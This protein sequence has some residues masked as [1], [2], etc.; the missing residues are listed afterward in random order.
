MVNASAPTSPNPVKNVSDDYVRGATGLSLFALLN[1]RD[2]LHCGFHS[3][4]AERITEKSPIAPS[5]ISIQTKRK[6]PLELAI[7]LAMPTPFPFMWRMGTP[8]ERSEPRSI[9]T[10]PDRRSAST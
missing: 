4:R 7:P 1:D 9:M 3:A 5:A 8:N 6:P 2:W 10:Y